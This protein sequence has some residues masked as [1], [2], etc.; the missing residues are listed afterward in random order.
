MPL[1]SQADPAET[2]RART[3]CGSD[4]LTRLPDCVAVPIRQLRLTSLSRP[5]SRQRHTIDFGKNSRTALDCLPA[6]YITCATGIW[7]RRFSTLMDAFSASRIAGDSLLV[8]H[9]ADTGFD[10]SNGPPLT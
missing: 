9:F 10:D 7:P 6:G 8:N 3:T 4:Y 2:K 5:L 1:A